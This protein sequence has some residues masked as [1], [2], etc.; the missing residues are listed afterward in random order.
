MEA[1]LRWQLLILVAHLHGVLPRREVSTP[2]KS[3]SSVASANSHKQHRHG[4]LP[5]QAVVLTLRPGKQ[6]DPGPPTHM[7]E[8]GLYTEVVLGPAHQHG[9]RERRRHT[10]PALATVERLVLDLTL[11]LPALELPDM[12]L[13]QRG[14]SLAAVRAEDTTHRLL[15]ANIPLPR[16]E[17]MAAPRLRVLLRLLH[18][19]GLT[20]RPPQVLRTL[21][22]LV[23]LRLCRS[24][25][26]GRTMLLR[27]LWACLRLR[28]R[29]VTMADRD[30]TKGLRVLD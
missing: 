24:V 26:V 15:E 21:L 18:V 27:L 29:W 11:F 9:Q 13:L 23:H 4:A 17:F 8:T 10:T 19:L 22:L 6:M 12:L 3:V 5:K 28:L 25:V 30:T 14:V 16:L 20:M 2:C 7:T 1:E